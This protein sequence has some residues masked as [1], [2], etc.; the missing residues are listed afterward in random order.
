MIKYPTCARDR[1]NVPPP[2]IQLIILFV[3]IETLII[4][5]FIIDPFTQTNDELL[6]FNSTCLEILDPIGPLTT[7]SVKPKTQ[8]WLN[9]VTRSLLND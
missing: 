2:Q 3:L 1:T 7:R 9:D 8:P 4:P 5:Y 6:S